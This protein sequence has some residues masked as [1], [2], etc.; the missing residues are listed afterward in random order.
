M[1]L[2]EEPLPSEDKVRDK[3]FFGILTGLLQEIQLPRQLQWEVQW[4][5][6]EQDQGVDVVGDKRRIAWHTTSR[7]HANPHRSG[8]I[9]GATEA[10]CVTAPCKAHLARAISLQYAVG[11]GDCGARG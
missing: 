2:D 8:H 10:V 3:I 7:S 4:Q 1:R 9:L 11:K 6:R 5:I